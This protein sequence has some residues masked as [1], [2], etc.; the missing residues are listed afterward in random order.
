MVTIRLLDFFMVSL[1]LDIHMQY[2]STL[3]MS[4]T[5][6]FT[7]SKSKHNMMTMTVRGSAPLWLARFMTL[8]MFISICETKTGKRQRNSILLLTQAPRF[9]CVTKMKFCQMNL[10]VLFSAIAIWSEVIR[11]HKVVLFLWQVDSLY[12]CKLQFLPT[13]ATRQFMKLTPLVLLSLWRPTA[14]QWTILSTFVY[15]IKESLS[16]VSSSASLPLPK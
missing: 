6:L 1:Q 10:E 14:T 12:F 4:K 16:N 7:I 11:T 8:A 2:Y 15:K 13:W 5:Y 9:I 3:K